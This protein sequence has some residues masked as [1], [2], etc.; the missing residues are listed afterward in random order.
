MKSNG[1]SY[2]ASTNNGPTAAGSQN[3]G[4]PENVRH[5]WFCYCSWCLQGHS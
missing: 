5:G 3:N 4:G 2:G 1:N